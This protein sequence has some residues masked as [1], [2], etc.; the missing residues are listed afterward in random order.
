MLILLRGYPVEHLHR[1][2]PRGAA[3]G[4][5]MISWTTNYSATRPRVAVPQIEPEPDA[6][7]R[8]WNA[9]ERREMAEA[10]AALLERLQRFHAGRDEADLGADARLGGRNTLRHRDDAHSRAHHREGR[11]W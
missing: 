1:G 10:S 6:W 9:V 5:T 7:P 2:Q 11:S 3:T 4:S 8:I